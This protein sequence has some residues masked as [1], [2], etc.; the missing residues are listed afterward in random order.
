[1]HENKAQNTKENIEKIARAYLEVLFHDHKCTIVGRPANSNQFVHI[2][3]KHNE[4]DIVV[5]DS[6]TAGD[7]KTWSSQ[8]KL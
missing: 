6:I 3:S 2:I 5:S 7:D 1:M 8:K 4:K